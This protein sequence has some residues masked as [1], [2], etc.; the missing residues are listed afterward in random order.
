M[1][2]SFD[3]LYRDLGEKG[4][5]QEGPTILHNPTPAE[6]CVN[7]IEASQAIQ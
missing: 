6:D 3:H 1:N 5:Q 4:D 2:V 7:I